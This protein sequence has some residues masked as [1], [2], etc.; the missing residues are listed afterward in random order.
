MNQR[1]SKGF[2]LI[3]LML[4]MGFVSV[5]LIA[6]AATVIQI[7]GV[8]NKGLLLKGADQTGRSLITELQHEISNSSAFDVVSGNGHYL[9]QPN[10]G[11]R[12]CTGRYSYVWNY[13]RTIFAGNEINVYITSSNPIKFAKVLDPDSSYCVAPAKKI[14]DADAVDLLATSQYDLAVQKFTITSNVSATDN[15]TNQQLY[16]IEFFIGTN[17]QNALSKDAQGNPTACLEPSQAGSDPLYC[18]FVQFNI[19]V[20]AGNLAQ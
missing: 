14:N 3:E 15:K 11:G 13:G 16:N 17:D 6:I 10:Q 18:S 7:S 1:H 8:Y 12:L 19:V 2:T 4:A 5:L 9:D 20:R